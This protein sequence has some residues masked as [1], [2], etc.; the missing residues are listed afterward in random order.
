MRRRIGDNNGYNRETD[1]DTL[2]IMLLITAFLGY[3]LLIRDARGKR[4]GFFDLDTTCSLRGFWALIVLLVHIPAQHQNPVQ[5]MLGSFAYIGVTF[6]FMTSAYG[7][8]LGLYRNPESLKRFWQRRL[9][10]LLL[11]MFVSNVLFVAVKSLTGADWNW[12]Q[13]FDITGWVR[14]LLVFYGIFL[15]I[16]GVLPAGISQKRKDSLFGIAIVL[17]SLMAQAGWMGPFQVWPTESFGFLYGVLLFRK[18]ERFVRFAERKWIAKFGGAFALSLTGGIGYLLL[19]HWP[20]WGDYLLKIFLGAAILWVLLLWNTKMAIGNRAGR[21][22]GTISYEIYLL[23]GTV[24]LILEAISGNWNSG[25]FVAVSII[26]TVI[27]GCMVHF[28]CEGSLRKW[29]ERNTAW[30]RN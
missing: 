28:I 2:A 1:M 11:P 15:V 16:Y 4:A 13:L 18:Q 10:Q 17:F 12:R 20:F 7:L 5:D 26:S 24:F 21:F 27:L 19:K 9:P 14:Q 30:R 22:L 6:F 3:L 8:F 29:K 25:V 23:H